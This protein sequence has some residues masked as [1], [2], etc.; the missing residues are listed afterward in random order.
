MSWLLT[1][2]V[3][4]VV[5]IPFAIFIYIMSGWKAT[6][7]IG[8]GIAIGLFIWNLVFRKRRPI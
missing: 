1:V 4:A 8:I 2:A 6:F 3:L 5:Y 7:A